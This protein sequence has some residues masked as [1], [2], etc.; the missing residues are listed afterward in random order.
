MVWFL[1]LIMWSFFP[2]FLLLLSTTTTTHGFGFKSILKAAS[3]KVSQIQQ[4]LEEKT[5]KLAE[6]LTNQ[7]QDERIFGVD[8]CKCTLK[9]SSK[10]IL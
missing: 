8:N 10:C 3:N 5:D 9:V 1:K 6:T 7:K 4:T 2:C